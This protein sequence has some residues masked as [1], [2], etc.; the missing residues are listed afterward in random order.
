[1]KVTQEKLPAS[2]IGLAIEIPAE[3]SQ[4]TYDQVI[5]KLTRTMNVPG[6][7]KGKVPR[8]ILLQRLGSVQVKAAALEELIQ[9][10]ITAAIK[11]EDIQAIGQPQLRSSFEELIAQYEPGQALQFSAAVDVQPEVNLTQYTDLHVKVE[12]VKYNPEKVDN[13]LTEQRNEMATLI[14]VEGR[15]AQLGD[16]AIVDFKGYLAQEEEQEPQEIAGA[17]ADDFQLELQQERFIPGFIDGIVGMQPGET[18][19]VTAQFPEDY[20][21][22]EVAGRAADFTVTLKEIK[23]KEL[24]ELNDDFAQAVSEFQTLAELRSSLEERFKAEAERQTKAN[25]EQALTN[26]LV[27][28]LEV[29][30]PETLIEQEVNNMLTQ[31]AVQLS[32]QGIDVKKLFTQESVAKL[33][34]NSRPEAIERLRSTLALQEIAQRESIKVEKPEVE[35]KAKEILSEYSNDDIDLNRLREVVEED[36]LKEKI[37]SWLEERSSVELLPEGSLDVPEDSIEVESTPS[38]PAPDDSSLS[39]VETMS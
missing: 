23:E 24:P 13:L 25:K 1:M 26:E 3:K 18:K 33:R 14:P 10:G 29:D 11:Q 31:A 19:E 30:L 5:Q 34:E 27:K 16:V 4:Q 9:T 7:R 38:D 17:S 8:Q 2:Q 39:E 28:Y 20:P 32:Q 22:Q 37:M 15:A 12:E 36:L 35:A 21:Q 6:F